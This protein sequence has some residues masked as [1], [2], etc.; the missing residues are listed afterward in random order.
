MSDRGHRTVAH[1]ADVIL[2]AWGPDQDTCCAEA[3]AALADVYLD[4]VAPDA[5]TESLAVT[6]EAATPEERLVALLEEIIF[7]LDTSPLP[8]IEATERTVDGELPADVALT[9]PAAV[10][11]AGAVPKAVSRSGLALAHDPDGTVRCSVLIDE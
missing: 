9:D 3:V 5:T 10:E 1:T 11:P 7:V 8:P 4:A 6:V 2:E